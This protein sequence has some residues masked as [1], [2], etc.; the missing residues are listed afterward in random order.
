MRLLFLNLK[1]LRYVDTFFYYRE[2]C[3]Y[4]EYIFGSRR[5]LNADPDR[6]LG[7]QLIWVWALDV[8]K[9]MSSVCFV[10]CESVEVVLS[11]ICCVTALFTVKPEFTGSAVFFI[12]KAC[13][14]WKLC[15]NVKKLSSL[16]TVS[17][18]KA[19]FMCWAWHATHMWYQL[20]SC[21]KVVAQGSNNTTSSVRAVCPYRWQ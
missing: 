11:E 3:P 5:Q 7:W 2:S 15:L 10:H 6:K 20:S 1:E 12:V 9:T 17:Y 16:K 4:S 19:I 13:L 21:C 14:V 8:V 18:L